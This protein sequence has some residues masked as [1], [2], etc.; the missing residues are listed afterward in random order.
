L[1]W[2]C[3]KTPQAQLNCQIGVTSMV[4]S[5]IATGVERATDLIARIRNS[6]SNKLSIVFA[7]VNNTTFVRMTIQAG[8]NVVLRKPV[9]DPSLRS[10]LDVALPRMAGQHRRY[11]RHKVNL[12]VEVLCHTGKVFAGK[13][14]NVSEGG[15]PLACFGSPVEKGVTV[16]FGLPSATPQAFEAEADVVWMTLS[17]WVE[18]QSHFR[19]PAQTRE[20]NI[21]RTRLS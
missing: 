4:S 7:V 13:M 1:T 5:L 16:K 17:L 12:P 21:W 8:T 9:F 19:E 18:A 14:M 6:R 20:C 11:F 15:L 2:K 3:A 10:L